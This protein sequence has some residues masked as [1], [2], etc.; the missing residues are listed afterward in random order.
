MTTGAL[1]AINMRTRLEDIF[2]DA[3][4]SVFDLALDARIQRK[5]DDLLLEGKGRVRDSDRQ[6]A[7]FEVRKKVQ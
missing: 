5:V 2:A 6:R 7:K 3:E 4:G 1:C